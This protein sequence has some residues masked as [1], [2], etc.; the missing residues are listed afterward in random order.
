MEQLHIYPWPGNVRELENVIRT[1]VIRT[2]G[3]VL[4]ITESQLPRRTETLQPAQLPFLDMPLAEGVEEYE[5]ARIK[6]AL[7]KCGGV[8]EGPDGAAKLLKKR[9]GSLRYKI[10]TLGI[11]ANRYRGHHGGEK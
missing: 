3:E 11:D 2:A 8:V 6:D 9:P 4:V 10:R 7:M 5:I 1:A